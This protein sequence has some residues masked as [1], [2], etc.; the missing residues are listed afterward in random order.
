MEDLTDQ[1]LDY[2]FDIKGLAA[3]RRRLTRAVGAYNG[4]PLR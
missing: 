2:G 1:D 3:L 4:D